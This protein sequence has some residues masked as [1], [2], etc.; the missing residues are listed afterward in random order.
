MRL[1]QMQ[2]ALDAC[3]RTSNRVVQA[4]LLA[5]LE[6]EAAA[7]KEFSMFAAALLSANQGLHP[8]PATG[9]TGVIAVS[10]PI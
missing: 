8:V 5:A 3:Y 1:S 2:N 9:G 4:T 6:D 10:T 7:N